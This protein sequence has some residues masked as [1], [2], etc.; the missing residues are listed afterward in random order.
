MT[1]ESKPLSTS[2]AEQLE[3]ISLDRSAALHDAPFGDK[4]AGR[5]A[6]HQAERIGEIVV[7]T[8]DKIRRVPFSLV[9]SPDGTL[10]ILSFLPDESCVLDK[11]DRQGRFLGEV[12]RFRTGSGRGELRSP[13]GVAVDDAG[14]F[15][16]P[17]AER[18]RIVKFNA[19]GRFL[20][21]LGAEG[22][23]EG[24]L[25]GPRDVEIG[26]D[27][28]ILVADTEN[29]RVQVWNPDGSFVAAFGAEASE[30]DE[31]PYLPKGSRAGEFFRPLGVT[32]DQEGKILV[33]DTNNHRIQRLSVERGFELEFGREGIEAG[34]LSFPIDVRID[35]SGRSVVADRA[36]MRVQWFNQKGELE[37][38]LALAGALAEG[39]AVADVDVDDEGVVYIPEGPTSRVYMVKAGAPLA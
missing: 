26:A 12:A 32:F 11:F 17:D 28:R 20:A 6:T 33:A 21:E 38:A 15:F 30:D 34:A 23:A 18:H 19:Q 29:H 25:F 37:V 31:S 4:Q 2:S 1:K 10:L 16:V 24:E 14:D 8:P 13:S 35:S 27:G 7:A 3:A 22:T 39:A 36:G 9:L 5:S